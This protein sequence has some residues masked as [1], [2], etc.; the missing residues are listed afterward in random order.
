MDI[1]ESDNTYSKKTSANDTGS[2]GLFKIG[3]Y[4]SKPDKSNDASSAQGGDEGGLLQQ[5]VNTVKNQAQAVADTITGSNSNK[6]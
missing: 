1:G 2:T 5:T 4:D 6:K 3:D